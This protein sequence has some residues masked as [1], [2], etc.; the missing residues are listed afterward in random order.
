MEELNVA[1]AAADGYLVT[2][3]G[4]GSQQ[5]LC[6]FQTELLLVGQWRL[7]VGLFKCTEE[8]PRGHARQSGQVIGGN[9]LC[10]VVIDEELDLDQA[11]INMGV[12]IGLLPTKG[13][14]LP[15]IS[16]G[17]TSAVMT[18]ITLGLLLRIQHEIQQA[19]VRDEARQQRKKKR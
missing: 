14:T 10:V 1:I 8:I 6:C 3:Q 19:A 17:R 5:G 11:F 15:L 7:P 18:L 4:C 13:L 12:N 16:Y 2:S 9:G